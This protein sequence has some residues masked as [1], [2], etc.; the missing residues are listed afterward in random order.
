MNSDDFCR[1]DGY[2]RGAHEYHAY[3]T[4]VMYNRRSKMDPLWNQCV[5]MGADF[6]GVC[7]LYGSSYT[8]NYVATGFASHL[9]LPLLRQHWKPD[10]SEEDATRLA[11]DCMRVCFY[12]D[13]RTNDK[14]VVGKIDAAGNVSVAEPARIN[15]YWE[16]PLFVSPHLY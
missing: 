16:H 5:V 13:C 12:R 14:V 11:I 7:D 2:V 3:L 1:D 15:T 6:L 8:D 10:M 9:A 4:R